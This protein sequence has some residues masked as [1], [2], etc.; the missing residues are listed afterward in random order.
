MTPYAC[1]AHTVVCPHWSS[2]VGSDHRSAITT[3]TTALKVQR[4]AHAQQNHTKP[5][6]HQTRRCLAL[7]SLDF[8]DAGDALRSVCQSEVFAASFIPSSS[9]YGSAEFHHGPL[10]TLL[11]RTAVALCAGAIFLCLVTLAK[12]LVIASSRT[13]TPTSPR[14]DIVDAAL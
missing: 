5:L 9:Q 10:G 13:S 1:V 4:P 6:H 8:Q 12:A 14:G 3:T 11:S 7:L 2:L